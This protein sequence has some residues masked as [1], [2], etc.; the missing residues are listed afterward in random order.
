MARQIK[1]M[2]PGLDKVRELENNTG[3]KNIPAIM[4]SPQG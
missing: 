1:V 4:G 2:N 3:Q